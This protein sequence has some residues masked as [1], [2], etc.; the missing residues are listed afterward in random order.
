MT[1]DTIWTNARLA[2]MAAGTA[3]LGIVEDG[4]IAAKDGRIVFAGPASE[5]PAGADAKTSIDCEGRWI[6]PGLVDCHT[7]LIYG[8]NRATEFAM[9][10]EGATYEEISRAGGGI[11]SSMKATRAATEQQLVA[12][13]LKRLDHLLAEG[14]TTIEIKS[15]YGLDKDTEIRCLTAARQL[16]RERDVSV[17]TS[18]LGAHAMP[19]EANG[20]KDAYIESVITEMLPAIA[21]LKLAD[22]V[23]AFCEGIAFSPEQTARVFD[24]AR[25]LGLPVKLHADQLSNLHGAKLAADYNALSADHLEHTDE[26]GVIALTRAGTVAVVLPGAYYTLRETQAP[27]IALFRKH[28]THLALATDSNPGTSPLTSLLLTMNM[29]AT[30]FR[31]TV[32]EC[33]LGVTREGARALGKLKD[34]GTLEAGKAC[35]LAIWDIEHPAELVYRV[36]FNPLHARVWHGQSHATVSK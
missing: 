3:G 23:D 34:V 16:G 5:L 9:R 13:G 1:F 31:M 35:D 2:T 25:K 36:G 32:D 4:C 24:A 30:L 29:G 17:I 28:G 8:G 27:P 11:A 12:S 15:G 6:T 19:P 33:L 20:D 22:A 10:L 26:D 7:H 21:E 14:V 18:F